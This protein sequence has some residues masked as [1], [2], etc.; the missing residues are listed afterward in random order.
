AQY[1]GPG[2]ILHKVFKPIV[3]WNISIIEVD[4]TNPFISIETEV[5]HDHLGTGLEKPTSMALRNNTAGHTVL[6]A[7]NGDYFGISAPTNPYTFLSN[8]QIKDEEY[9]FGRTHSRS[10]FGY[11]INKKPF[12]EIIDFSGTVTASN[13]LSYEIAGV[14]R[15]RGTD[16][17]IVYN[18]YFS[19]TTLTN[20]FGTEVRLNSIDPLV[21]NSAI[22]FIVEAK[23]SSVGSMAVN[24]K[25]I[26]SGNEA[27]STFINT[28][29]SIGDTIT[30]LMGSS[31]DRGKLS[32]LIGGGP[33]LIID[34]QIPP[35][36]DGFEGFGGTHTNSRHP[37]TAVGFGL[38]STKL[39]L[40]VVDGR[41]G[42]LSAGMTIKELAGYMK[43]I[44]CTDAVNLDGGGSSVLV[45]RNQIASSP[46][47]PGGERSV[48]N[49]LIIVSSSLTGSLNRLHITPLK[50]RLF[51]G[52]QTSFSVQGTDSNYNPIPLT[53][54]LIQWRLSKPSLGVISATGSFTA[55]SVS[56]SGYV[57]VQY[58][59]VSDSTFIVVKG[60]KDIEI[61]PKNAVTD[62]SRIVVFKA[63]LFDTDNILQTVNPLQLVWALSDS[64][65][66]TLDVLGQFKGKKQG[67]TKVFVSFM[68]VIDTAE[69]RVEIVE[70]KHVVDSL[71]YLEGWNIETENLD[72]ASLYLNSTF[73]SIGEKSFQVD[74]QF[75]Y[76]P[77]IYNWVNLKNIKPTIGLP[78]SIYIDVRSDGRSHRVF[79][80]IEDALGVSY[81]L[82]T[83]K[84]A[85]DSTSF[86][87]LKARVPSSSSVI[88]PITIKNIAVAFGNGGT[89]GQ[90]Y[91]GKIYIDNL[92]V[93]YPP[94]TV[95]VK[96]ENIVPGD[97][98]LYQNYPN[99]FNPST[100]I[101]FAIKNSSDVKLI[102]FD[103]F[104]REVEKLVNSRVTP[105]VYDVQFNASKY[106]SGVYFYRLQY[107]ASTD[108]KKLILMK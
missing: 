22:R 11:D 9:V 66:G 86:E 30:L 79:F 46:S 32:G 100:T 91:S 29:I 13:G 88:F 54:S 78:D 95:G 27:A 59:N 45:A 2:T 81:R 80:D 103:I 38:D 76:Q 5:A 97:F 87:T 64:T 70:G 71:E 74:Y 57:I 1:I 26:L 47:D 65:I 34:G 72:S 43:S 108:T 8:S 19:S 105:G 52:Q 7:I 69:V 107:N 96:D 41:Q 89:A 17:L 55:A 25:Y 101:R 58:Q 90:Q 12:V 53:S 102:V 6:G 33:R 31:P 61:K 18:K 10:S 68:D 82:N 35:N 77:N 67:T 60:I 28:N 94:N 75:T 48:G 37:R 84:F 56:D 83:N 3:P 51:L 73:H 16:Q 42:L 93:S 104:G 85:S 20:Q 50:P 62:N 39:Y 44:G 49:A 21:A 99:P 15:E 24:G 106:A 98:V 14:N 40:L 4:L 23:E 63:S 92:Q 36:F